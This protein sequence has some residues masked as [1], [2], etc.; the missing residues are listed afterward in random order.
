MNTRSTDLRSSCCGA[1]VTIGGDDDDIDGKGLGGTHYF[2]CSECDDSC[3]TTDYMSGSDL[4]HEA[5][6]EIARDNTLA[7]LSRYGDK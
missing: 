3:D 6:Q 1:P 2:I 7:A 5:E 4:A